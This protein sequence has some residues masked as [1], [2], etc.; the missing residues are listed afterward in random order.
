MSCGGP[1]GGIENIYDSY[2]RN[3]NKHEQSRLNRTKMSHNLISFLSLV[4]VALIDTSTSAVPH[5]SEIVIFKIDYFEVQCLVNA[6]KVRDQATRGRTSKAY[7]QR[8]DRGLRNVTTLDIANYIDGIQKSSSVVDA[9]VRT[10]THR[11][12]Q[13]NG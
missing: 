4:D 1:N 9:A 10:G 5:P 6:A 7:C 13:P 11:R 2:I 12:R 8:I 3:S